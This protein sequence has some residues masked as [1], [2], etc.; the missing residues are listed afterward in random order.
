[1]PREI[2]DSV[3]EK[4]H[5]YKMEGFC[6]R[7]AVWLCLVCGEFQDKGTRL[8]HPGGSWCYC[9]EVLSDGLL[10][11]HEQLNVTYKLRAK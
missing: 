5:R 10:F 6:H 7:C 2:E 1:M 8:A 9:P 11:C 4:R 3:N